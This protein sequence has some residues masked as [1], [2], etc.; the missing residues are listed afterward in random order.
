MS[1]TN[2]SMEEGLN[3]L[4]TVVK[5]GIPEE[6]IVI[7]SEYLEVQEKTEVQE[8]IINTTTDH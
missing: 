8:E 3:W 1:H 5:S 2:I 6:V 4:K 7:L